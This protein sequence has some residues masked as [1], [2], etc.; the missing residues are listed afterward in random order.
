MHYNHA[1]GVG[2]LVMWYDKDGLD[3]WRTMTQTFVDGT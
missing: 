2:R 1:A 3:H